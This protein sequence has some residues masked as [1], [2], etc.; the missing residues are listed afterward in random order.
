MSEFI[1][2]N[3]IPSEG[4]EPGKQVLLKERKRHHVAHFEGEG[5][6]AD[7]LMIWALSAIQ[8]KD[9][10]VPILLVN[11]DDFDK[12]MYGDFEESADA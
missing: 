7:A 9:G 2:F 5:E 1:R 6:L 11:Q 8:N 12:G 4:I 10:Q 3:I